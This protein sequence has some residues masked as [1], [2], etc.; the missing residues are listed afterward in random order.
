[1]RAW[2]ATCSTVRRR[3]DWNQRPRRPR[4]RSVAMPVMMVMPVMPVMVMMVMG[5]DLDQNLCL[6]RKRQ[7]QG[8]KQGNHGEESHIGVLCR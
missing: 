6:G 1:M 5:A 4:G 2:P 3:I 8:G 7:Y